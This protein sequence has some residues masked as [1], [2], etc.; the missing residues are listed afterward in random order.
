[1]MPSIFCQD[2]S[3]CTLPALP[4]SQNERVN[5]YQVS[6]D[7]VIAENVIYINTTQECTALSRLSL[8]CH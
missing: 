6:K 5:I 4:N 3:K 7:P 8:A 1:M 2:P